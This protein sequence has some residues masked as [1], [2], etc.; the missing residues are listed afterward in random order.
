MCV[1]DME[2]FC[3]YYWVSHLSLG[4]STRVAA[5]S[6]VAR[7]HTHAHSVL[8]LLVCSLYVRMNPLVGYT[9]ST[10]TCTIQMKTFDKR[11]SFG[12][13]AHSQSL[14]LTIVILISETVAFER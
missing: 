9:Q 13:V 1:I 5:V 2:T 12:H 14:S 4:H 3:A 8:P 11:I 10:C 6:T 7:T